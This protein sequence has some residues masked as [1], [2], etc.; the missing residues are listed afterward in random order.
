MTKTRH[1]SNPDSGSPSNNRDRGM[2]VEEAVKILDEKYLLLLAAQDNQKSALEEQKKELQDKVQALMVNIQVQKEAIDKLQE[3]AV[4]N[5]NAGRKIAT[6][7]P[8]P[9]VYSG[10]STERNS[11]S[12]RAF[13]FRVEK[14]AQ[15]SD[16]DDESTLAMTVCHLDGR[17]ATWYMREENAGRN[18]ESMD[19]LRKR[20]FKEFV[21]SIEKSQAKM[22]LV[23]LRMVTKDDTDKHIDRFEE[24]M[25]T[26]ETDL[27]EAYSY[28]FMTLPDSYKEDLTKFFEGEVPTEIY[29]AYK[30]VRT[31]AMAKKWT[32]HAAD[33]TKVPDKASQDTK[34][35]SNRNSAYTKSG[36]TARRELK[37]DDDNWGKARNAGERVVYRAANRCF[38]CGKSGWTD[39]AHPCRK[40][41]GEGTETKN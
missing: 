12:L 23:A 15:F 32:S 18:P 33:K 36:N 22:E 26:S 7:A 1:H 19:D 28:F 40:P 34:G 39:P 5:K 38:D 29:T 31:I 4:C 27:S 35:S 6:K 41:S 37:N 16:M 30:R 24:L 8:T 17:A 20:M 21:P 10:K 25:E 11:T 14:A 3:S 2:A 13:F 9:A